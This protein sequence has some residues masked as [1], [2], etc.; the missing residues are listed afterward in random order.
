VQKKP[1]LKK[2]IYSIVFTLFSSALFAQKNITYFN[3]LD[4]SS[5][6]KYGSY[7]STP[8]GNVYTK[9]I[10][11]VKGD[12]SIANEWHY[13]IFEQ[14]Q[15]F[16]SNFKL[17][18]ASE[19]FVYSLRESKDSIFSYLYNNG[20]E[21][22]INHATSHL[23]NAYP[24]N[25]AFPKAEI[26]FTTY[27]ENQQYGSA[28]GLMQGIGSTFCPPNTKGVLYFECYSKK[29]FSTDVAGAKCV[30]DVK[31]LTA[32]QESKTGALLLYPNPIEN[33]LFFQSKN[34]FLQEKIECR[35]FD[36][37]GILQKEVILDSDDFIDTSALLSGVYMVK[38][39]A[40]KQIFNYKI[41][42][43]N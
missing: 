3:F 35:I 27:Y 31:N 38:I 14:I 11:Y 17:T 22:V 12:T 1:M 8:S 13:K 33:E 42:K 18:K 43:I 7:N 25:Q 28:C 34:D 30:I 10:F 32:S 36:S 40:K 21:F 6:W 20:N 41:V 2:C 39:Q 5:Q 15:T 23:K 4:Y 26:P 37:K 29:G 9:S 24:Y 19:K 16:D